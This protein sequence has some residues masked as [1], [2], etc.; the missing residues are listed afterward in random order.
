MTRPRLQPYQAEIVRR[1]LTGLPLVLRLPRRASR[2]M[3]GLTY[4][5]ATA[6]VERFAKLMRDARY[7][8]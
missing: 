4:A 2:G 3:L 1:A 5:E 6:A 8:L 7:R